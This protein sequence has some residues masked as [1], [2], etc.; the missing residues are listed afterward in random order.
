MT[1]LSTLVF[2]TIHMNGTSKKDL[3]DGYLSA[4]TALS[5][6]KNALR[7]TAPH[8][9]DYYVSPDPEAGRQADLQF[10]SRMRRLNDVFEEIETILVYLQD[11]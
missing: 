10:V 6:A 9:R 2:P 11:R 4:Y 7:A 3:Y 8:Q 5:A 1:D